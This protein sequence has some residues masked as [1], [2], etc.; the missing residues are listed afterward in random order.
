MTRP[1][2]LRIVLVA[3]VVAALVAAVAVFAQW[4]GQSGA[5]AVADPRTSGVPGSVSISPTARAAL[6]WPSDGEAA[7]AVA[8]GP[9][10]ASS[11]RALPMA[12]VSKLVTALMVL[13]KRPL[14]VGQGGDVY[15]F[16]AKWAH[17]YDE[18]VAR[19]QSALK[20]PV[21]GTATQYQLIQ[22]M[23]VGS[24]CNYADV[25]VT[26]V[27]GSQEAFAPA[28]EAFLT[29]NGLDGITMVEPTGFDA[30]NTATPAALIALGRLALANPVIAQ[31]VKMRSVTLPG[32]GTVQ[33]TNDLLADTG[34]VGIKTGTLEG[35][36]LLSAKDVV[37]AG[38]KVVRVYVVVMRQPDDEARFAASRDLYA[39]V[40]RKIGG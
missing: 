8:D 21:G 9:V 19:G 27:W 32:A 38:G 23:L 1:R 26:T 14:R 29:A 7:V 4:A 33:N 3:I 40:E 34:V 11:T 12:S 5:P 13:E 16:S 2:P 36:N 15:T 6:T 20:L 10:S 17:N 37:G 35:T 18:Y 28:A 24:A 22:G 31:I 39:Q 25:L 30:R